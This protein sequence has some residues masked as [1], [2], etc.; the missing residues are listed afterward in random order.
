MVTKRRMEL[1]WTSIS[2]FISDSLNG[3]WKSSGS[4]QANTWGREGE[5]ERDEKRKREREIKRDK[6]GEGEE[7]ERLTV[8][9][10]KRLSFFSM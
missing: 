7:Q 2:L 6:E 5:R 3:F 10:L 1:T 9:F 8:C 4:L